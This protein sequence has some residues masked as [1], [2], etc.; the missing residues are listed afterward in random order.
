MLC[1]QL[2]FS[3][4]SCYL[5]SPGLRTGCP[6]RLIGGACERQSA[7]FTQG[8]ILLY[9]GTFFQNDA[10]IEHQSE[11]VTLELFKNVKKNIHIPTCM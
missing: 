7:D 2:L 8:R 6:D 1:E 5:G 10:G 3:L 11:T 9:I 4:Y